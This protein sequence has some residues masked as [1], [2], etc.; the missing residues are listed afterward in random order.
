MFKNRKYA[1]Y[2]KL[3][4]CKETWRKYIKKDFGWRFTSKKEWNKIKFKNSSFSQFVVYI[5]YLN[6]L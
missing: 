4:E 6:L 2:K 3:L 5:I 1:E